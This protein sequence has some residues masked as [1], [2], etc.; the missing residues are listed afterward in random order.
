MRTHRT[1]VFVFVPVSKLRGQVPCSLPQR[2]KGVPEQ[3]LPQDAEANAVERCLA[4]NPPFWTW[5]VEN[6]R[7][8]CKS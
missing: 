7:P 6:P 5:F 2:D 3:I 4:G 1:Y 8:C